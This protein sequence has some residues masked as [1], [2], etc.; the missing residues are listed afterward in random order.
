MIWKLAHVPDACLSLFQM[1]SIAARSS[2]SR[3][4]MNSLAMESLSESLTMRA[5]CCAAAGRHGEAVY[6]RLWRDAQ[7]AEDFGSAEGELVAGHEI[8]LDMPHHVRMSAEQA[9]PCLLLPR[10]ERGDHGLGMRHDPD[11]ILRCH[12]AHVYAC[13]GI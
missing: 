13:A 5:S 7:V 2:S 3:G 12:R 11:H 9:E 1:R 6:P 4:A 8:C 10:R